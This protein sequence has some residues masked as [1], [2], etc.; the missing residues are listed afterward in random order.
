MYQWIILSCHS[1]APPGKTKYSLRVSQTDMTSAV[2]LVLLVGD[3]LPQHLK[4]FCGYPKI[5]EDY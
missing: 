2:G 4:L 1:K 3:R 5:S